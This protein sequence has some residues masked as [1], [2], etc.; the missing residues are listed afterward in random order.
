MNPD[1]NQFEGLEDEKATEDFIQRF[2]SDERDAGK[3]IPIFTMGEEI[4]IRGYIFQVIQINDDR[5][6]LR[7]LRKAKG[8]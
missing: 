4:E 2:Y 8:E 6:A 3:D 1:T 7:P 5:L